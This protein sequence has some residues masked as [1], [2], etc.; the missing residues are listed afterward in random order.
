VSNIN[1]KGLSEL[2]AFLD[3]LPAKMEA[4]IM[5]SA[6]RAGA[7]VILKQARLNVAAN[8]SRETGVLA[9]GLK[10]STSNR[11]GVVKA[12]V[13]ATGKHGH[14]A[15]WLEYGVAAHSIRKGARRS[16]GKLQDGK[17]HPGFDEK[18]FL[19][20]ALDGEAQ[21]ALLAVGQA[22]KQRLTKQGLD[23]SGVNLEP[24]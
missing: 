4:N 3:Q 18:P 11:R 10:V 24:A 14:I 2:Q 21:A 5:R 6:L 17:L 19:R 8:G 9:R 12:T 15:N 13:K 1:V 16:R 22:V 23:A 7:N 20:P